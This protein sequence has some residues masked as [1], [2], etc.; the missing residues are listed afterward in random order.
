MRLTITTPLEIVVD[1]TD[2]VHLRAED[3][4]G[5]FGILTGHADFLTALAVS[6]VSWRDRRGPEH[7]VAVRGGMLQVDGAD[8]IAIATREAVPGEDLARLESEVLTRFRR[9]IAEEQAARTDA[10]RL[11]LAAIRR[12]LRYV[13]PDRMAAQIAV[14]IAA[15]LPEL[16]Q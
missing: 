14:P 6:V 12:I 7:H 9:S 2:V 13:R 15:G 16:D 1:T 11:Y 3:Q 4:T 10:Q 8:G 5:G